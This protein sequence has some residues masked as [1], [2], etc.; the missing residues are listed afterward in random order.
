MASRWLAFQRKTANAY[1]GLDFI[2]DIPSDKEAKESLSTDYSGEPDTPAEA[3]SP[4]SP[5]APPSDASSSVHI[6]V[7][8]LFIYFLL[9]EG[10]RT[11]VAFS[12]INVL[13]YHFCLYL[14]ISRCS[15]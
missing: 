10:P 8:F 7:G 3:H 1:P 2:F 13:F 14:C 4:S 12:L 11:Y 9:G 5:S 6:N 15:A